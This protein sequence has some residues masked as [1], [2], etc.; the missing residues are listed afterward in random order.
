MSETESN[1]LRSLPSVGK[2]LEDPL[3]ADQVGA[4]PAP[5][6]AAVVRD[7][8]AEVRAEVRASGEPVRIES[9][10]GRLARRLDLYRSGRPTRVINGTGVVLHTNLGRAVLGAR[11]GRRLMDVASAYVD[12]ELDVETGERGRREAHVELLLRTVSGAEAAL[13]VN[14]CAAAVLLLL[15]TFA[16]GREVVVSR[17]ELVEIG[18]AFRIPDVLRRSGAELVEVG[19]TNKTHPTDYERAITPG[20]AVLLKVHTSNYRVVGFTSA[21]PASDLVTL[22]EAHDVVVIEDLGSG[23]PGIPGATLPGD[24]PTLAGE[25]RAGVHLVAASGDK[26]LGGPQAGLIL[27][28]KDLVERAATNPLY[29]A[30][31]PDKLTLAALSEALT[32]HLEGTASDH[33]PA[34]DMLTREPDVLAA[35]ADAL[36]RTLEDR[37]G[38]RARVTVEDDTS[39]TGGGAMPTTDLPTRV[40]TV[41]PQDRPVHRVE[42]ALRGGDPPVLLRILGDRLRIDPRTLLPGDDAVVVDRLDAILGGPGDAADPAGGAA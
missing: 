29:R 21:V 23:W 36:A 6:A 31:R 13:V 19:T 8:V 37:L 11:V 20:T 7:L 12:L 30:L 16:R 15:D 28:R 22:A 35:A 42:A 41:A 10:R 27:G 40:V 17:G 24:E 32:I 39:E 2:L 9:I 14:N 3:L 4:L 38:E 5:L 34:V 33:L 18:G 25:I 26:L 1:A